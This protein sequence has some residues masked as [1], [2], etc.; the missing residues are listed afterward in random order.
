MSRQKLIFFFQK[1]WRW[2]KKQLLL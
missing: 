2:H 1:Q